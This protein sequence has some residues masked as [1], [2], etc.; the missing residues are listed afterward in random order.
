MFYKTAEK[1]RRSIWLSEILLLKKKLKAMNKNNSENSEKKNG[2]ERLL[3]RYR[4]SNPEVDFSEEGSLEEYVA[5]D[6]DSY[7]ERIKKYDENSKRLTDLFAS[8]V[9]A[10]SMLN[11]W[12]SGQ[13]PVAFL[14]ENFGDE[15]KAALDSPEG[16]DAFVESHNKWLEKRTKDESLKKE[17]DENFDNSMQTLEAWRTKHGLSEDEAVAVFLKVHSIGA[18]VVDGIYTE[19]SLDMANK[20]MNYDNDV[21]IAKEDGVIE[22]RNAKIEERLRESKEMLEQAPTLG[23]GGGAVPE[24]HRERKK[25]YYDVFAL[26]DND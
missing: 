9:M 19:E 11:A 23:G 16:R 15:F 14:L 22:G 24:T 17:R 1:I 20:A 13:N 26:E 4:T 6:L 25:S 21:S 18:D 3:E 7:S 5:N 10:A 2:R 8:N 12:A